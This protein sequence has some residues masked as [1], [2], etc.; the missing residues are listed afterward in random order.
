MINKTVVAALAITL[1][2]GLPVFAQDAPKPPEMTAQQAKEEVAYAIGLQACLW[3]FPL[4]FNA[5]A[6]AEGVKAGG[7]AVN[8]IHKF[9]ALKTAKDRFIVTP[10]NVTI[11]GYGLIELRE[12]VVIVV[13]PLAEPRW[14][15]VQ[16]GDMFDEVAH[17][18]AGTRG[19]EPGV[20]LVTGP[21]FEGKVPGDMKQVEIRTKR[22][23][24]GL[25]VLVRGE[26]DLPKALEAQKGFRLIPLSAYLRDGLAYKPPVE[27][28]DAFV[29]HS[30]ETGALGYFDELGQAMMAFLSASADSDDELVAS[31]RQIGLSVGAGFQPALIDEP[32][33]RG[34]ERA[35]ASGSAI[36]DSK[37]AAAGNTVDGW[38]YTFAGG[39]AGYDPALRAALAKYELGAQLSD[40]VIYPN[41]SVDDTGEK[42]T[43]NRKYVLQFPAGGQPP[44]SVFWNMAMYA[45]D[46]LFVDNDFGRYSIGST[47][48]GLK[49]EADGSL[50]ILIQNEKPAETANWLPAPK[51]EFNLTLRMYGPKTDVLDGTYHIP[52][53]RQAK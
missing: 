48:D 34:L 16:I 50:T 11:D 49:P 26:A 1:A 43:G 10:N 7:V 45:P 5:L 47:T 6:G 27:K 38:K 25:R 46:M 33:K 36:I 12:P 51:G 9:T 15:I 35:A 8:D 39:R 20:Y 42:L 41:T 30:S 2:A 24:V 13:P 44:V 18:V 37:W 23:V 32:V 14:Y 52:A 53:V 40:Q 22:A 3:G 21:D 19:P 17:N 29:P 31:F 4:R 28:P